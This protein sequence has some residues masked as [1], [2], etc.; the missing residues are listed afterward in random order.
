MASHEDPNRTPHEENGDHRDKFAWIKG[1]MALRY[2][3]DDRQ[4]ILAYRT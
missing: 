3:A 2:H 4:M 1:D